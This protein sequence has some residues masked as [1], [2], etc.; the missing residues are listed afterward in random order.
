MWLTHDHVDIVVPERHRSASILYLVGLRAGT[1]STGNNGKR[2]PCKMG[3]I[4]G[5]PYTVRYII[6]L[7]QQQKIVTVVLAI[8]GGTYGT[9]PTFQPLKRDSDTRL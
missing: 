9:V 8:F 2:N 7:C 4:V 6:H 3:Y 1:K 5:K